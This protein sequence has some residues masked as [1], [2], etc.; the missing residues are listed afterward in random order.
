MPAAPPSGA[1]RAERVAERPGNAVLRWVN[2]ALGGQAELLADGL[3]DDLP[4]DR[5]EQ[6]EQVMVAQTADTASRNPPAAGNPP[7]LPEVELD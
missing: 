5:L 7:Q 2:E 6:I 3:A 4:D 1:D